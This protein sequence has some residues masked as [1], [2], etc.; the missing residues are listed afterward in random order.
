M[1]T[2]DY[3]TRNAKALS[4]K[5]LSWVCV[6]LIVLLWPLHFYSHELSTFVS[7][8]VILTALIFGF[9][10]P[11]EDRNAFAPFLWCFVLSLALEVATP[12]SWP[13]VRAK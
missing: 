11:R 12:T 1:S 2:L 13:A 4:P 10:V 3:V 6:V 5:R 7:L 9:F 8:S